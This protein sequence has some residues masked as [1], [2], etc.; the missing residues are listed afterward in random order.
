MHSLILFLYFTSQ[1]EKEN[2][3]KSKKRGYKFISKEWVK[4]FFSIPLFKRHW[5][6][7]LFFVCRLVPIDCILVFCTLMISLHLKSSSAWRR[8]Y[9]VCTPFF[10]THSSSLRIFVKESFLFL[11]TALSFLIFTLLHVSCICCYG[12]QSKMEGHQNLLLLSVLLLLLSHTFSSFFFP[13]S[14][15]FFPSQGNK[16]MIWQKE[17]QSVL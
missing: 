14:S 2:T 11:P 10:H 6:W 4:C 3:G 1:E 15:P 17:K 13:F 12:W 5:T 7:F 16:K 9:D 8:W